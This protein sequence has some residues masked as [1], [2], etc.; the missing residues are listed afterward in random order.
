MGTAN[1]PATSPAPNNV[2][3]AGPPDAPTEGPLDERQAAYLAALMARDAGARAQAAAG[4]S[5]D[6][7]VDS[8]NEALFD[9]VGDTVIEFGDAGPQ[10][11]EDYRNDIEELLI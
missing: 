4:T 2:A 9:V 5:E 6:M 10:V 8:I 1:K 7:L 11:V 3:P